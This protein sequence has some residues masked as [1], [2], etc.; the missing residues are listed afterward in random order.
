MDNFS[1][2]ERFTLT[3]NQFEEIWRRFIELEAQTIGGKEP[4]SLLGSVAKYKELMRKAA[5]E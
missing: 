3:D 2:H 5:T 1:D 4:K